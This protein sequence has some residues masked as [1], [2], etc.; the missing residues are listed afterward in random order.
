MT[1]RVR[2]KLDLSLL[3]NVSFVFLFLVP[4]LGVLLLILRRKRLGHPSISVH[5]Y[6]FL[7]VSFLLW[8]FFFSATNGLLLALAVAMVG[9]MCFATF[10]L[11]VEESRMAKWSITIGGVSAV[12]WMAA[13]VLPVMFFELANMMRN[14]PFGNAAECSGVIRTAG[15]NILLV[16]GLFLSGARAF[17]GNASLLQGYFDEFPD[18]EG[19][20]LVAS[21]LG[22]IAVITWPLMNAAIPNLPLLAITCLR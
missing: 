7:A 21:F 1:N 2:Y 4:W 13:V 22:L 11:I 12:I 17:V 10:L 15:I 20:Y 3:E 6:L 9:S 18:N 14:V 8:W 16:I 5:D 19:I